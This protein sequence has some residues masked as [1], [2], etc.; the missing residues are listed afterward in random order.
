MNLIER[1]VAS[2]PA[3]RRNARVRTV[4]SFAFITAVHTLRTGWP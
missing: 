4:G 3:E 1:M 2:L